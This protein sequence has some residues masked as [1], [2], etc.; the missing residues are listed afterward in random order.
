MAVAEG[1]HVIEPINRL[2]RLFERKDWTIFFTRDWHP[3]NHCSFKV[4]GGPWPPHCIA[5][6]YGADFHDDL[7]VPDDVLIISKA[8]TPEEEA[9]SSFK[10]TTLEQQLRERGI[11]TVLLVGL[12]TDYCIKNSALDAHRFGFNVIV[13]TDAIRAVNLKPDDG[14]CA[15]KHMQIRGVQFAD[16][17]E[18]IKQLESQ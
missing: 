13:A 9:Y 10:G 18:V 6:T 1:D 2:V 12:T 5:D 16:T 14:R 4:N 11:E 3:P 17:D 8:T 15:I 7:Y